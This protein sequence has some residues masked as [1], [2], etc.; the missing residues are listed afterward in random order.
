MKELGEPGRFHIVVCTLLAITWWSV[1]LG[2]TSM[3]FYG[4]TP[5]KSCVIEGAGDISQLINGSLVVPEFNAEQIKRQR[6]STD[7]LKVADDGSVWNVTISQDQCTYNLTD[8]ISTSQHKCNKWTYDKE[9]ERQN[10]IATEVSNSR[11]AFSIFVP[12]LFYTSSCCCFLP[13][14]LFIVLSGGQ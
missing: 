10:T 1:A 8:G 6:R 2:N 7:L 11:R 3:T 5:D 12:I 4:F 9:D 14:Q 13:E